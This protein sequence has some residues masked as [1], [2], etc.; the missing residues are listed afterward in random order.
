MQK[1]PVKKHEGDE[2]KDLLKWCEIGADM[3]DGVAGRNQSIG[4]DKSVHFVSQRHLEK[5][6]DHIDADEG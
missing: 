6:H 2:G 1:T 3:R 4:I 5:K